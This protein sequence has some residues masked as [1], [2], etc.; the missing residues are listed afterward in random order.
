MENFTVLP[1]L[2][3]SYLTQIPLN[4]KRAIFAHIPCKN[5]RPFAVQFRSHVVFLIED[6]WFSLRPVNKCTP[7]NSWDKNLINSLINCIYM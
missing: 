6:V 7:L 3:L 1:V 4:S 5:D 2:A